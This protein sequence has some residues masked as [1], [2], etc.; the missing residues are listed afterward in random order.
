MPTRPIQLLAVEDDPSLS[1]VLEEALKHADQAEIAAVMA[2]NLE[3]ALD[4]IGERDFEVILL[5]LSLPD[6]D[7]PATYSAVRDAAGD[8]PIVV[9]TGQDDPELAHRVQELGA[10]DFLLKGE[11]GSKALIEHIRR[12]AGR[13]GTEEVPENAEDTA[14]GRPG[15]AAE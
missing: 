13:R 12:F 11:I 10:E 3:E 15:T 4:H 2:S 8:V 1:F 9:L 14:G 6:S 7:G 5:D